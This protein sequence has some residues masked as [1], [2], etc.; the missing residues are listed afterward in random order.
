MKLYR[1]ITGPD[2]AACCHRVT[3]AL[4]DG[5]ELHGSPSLTYNAQ[6]SQVMCGQSVTKTIHGRDYDPDKKL[7]EQ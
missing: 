7:T 5:W 2:D 3:A 1:F 6:T 4:N